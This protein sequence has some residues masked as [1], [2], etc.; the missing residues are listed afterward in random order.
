MATEILIRERKSAKHGTTYA[1]RFETA[2]IGGKRQW[3]SKSGFLSAKEAKTAGLS[4]LNEYNNCGKVVFDSSISF[5]DFLDIWIEQECKTTLKSITVTGYLKKIKN[6]IKPALG[7][8]ALKNIRKIDL[9]N[10]LNTMHDNGYSKNSVTE[11]KGILTKCL[12]YAVDEKYLSVSPAI[13]VKNPKSEFTKVPTRSAPHSYLSPEK[14]DMIF[15][16]FPR[17]STSHIPLL[18]GYRCGL[19]IGE[20]FG[21]LWDD[22]DF[23][24]KTLLVKRQIQWKQNER[25]KE[26]IAQEN[27]RKSDD[28]GY[29]YFSNP[30]YNSFRTI[31]LDDE[32]LDILRQEKEQQEAAKAYFRERYA[33]YFVDEH[34]RIN[35]AGNGEQISFVCVRE[36]GMYT[37]PRT[38]QHTSSIIHKQLL[39]PEFDYHSLRHT[40]TTMLIEHGAPIKYVQARLGHKN[41]DVTL[42]IYQHLTESLIAQG[43]A[44]LNS[45]FIQ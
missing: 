37:T 18:L 12:S 5:A 43:S 36:N 20:T 19:R 21:L 29:W 26:V 32:L 38:L 6:H 8:Y 39:M 34:R 14:M 15:R 10:F 1:Y 23:N 42:N 7:K 13:G 27:G 2:S 35:T 25:P 22:I 44:T 28:S 4:A 3:I 9:Q 24:A 45:M 17:R 16:R 41:I 40:H 31:E 33:Q 11:T 30:K